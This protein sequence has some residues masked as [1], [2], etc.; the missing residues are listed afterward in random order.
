MSNLDNKEKE[1]TQVL[2][3]ITKHARRQGGT[4]TEDE[5]RD[6]FENL[7]LSD[8]QYELIYDYLKKHNIGIGETI[9][10]SEYL[11]E[12]ESGYLSEYLEELSMIE[13]VSDGEKEAIIISAMA[14]ETDA[15][16]KLAEISLSMVA[17]V[18]KL[19]AEQGVLI[20]DLIGE[21]NIALM[22][23]VG[24]LSNMEDHKE[25]DAFLAQMVMDAMENLIED[26]AAETARA[27]KAVKLVQEV[28]D[29]AKELADELRRSCTVDELAEETGWDRAKILEA[30]K[31]C[32]NQIEDIDYKPEKKE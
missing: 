7:E 12:E 28:A 9:D 27:Q 11:S 24:D 30:I 19:Y 21:G 16:K 17:D 1:F 26:D 2:A 29:K 4:V 20:E 31:A 22:K 8:A 18:A 14:G 6:A 3:D 32:G 25:C 13:T 23:A 5:I 15:Q 10:S